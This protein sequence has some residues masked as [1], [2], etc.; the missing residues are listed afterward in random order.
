MS[1]ERK[2]V[3]IVAISHRKADNLGG[4][5]HI[6]PSG[7]YLLH[8]DPFPRRLILLFKPDRLQ[9][10]AIEHNSDSKPRIDLIFTDCR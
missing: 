10:G 2:L 5:V 4:S 8:E 3:G 7:A 6:H 1:V 9:P